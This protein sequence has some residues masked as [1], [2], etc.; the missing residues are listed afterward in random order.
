MTDDAAGN[1]TFTFN[2]P[3]GS[4]NGDNDLVVYIA[5][6]AA[7][8]TDTSSLVDNGDTGRAAVSGYEADNTNVTPEG[9]TRTLVTFA[10]GF[11]ANYALSIQNSYESLFSLPLPNTDNFLTYITGTGQNNAA[12]YTLTVPL[13]DLGLAQG[14]SFQFDATLIGNSHLPVERNDRRD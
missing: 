5:T 4:L 3:V 7:G 13:A 11:G 14:A 12:P 10:P 6:G 9:S 2:T 8:L 1:V